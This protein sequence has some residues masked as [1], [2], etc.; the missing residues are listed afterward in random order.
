MKNYTKS[1]PVAFETGEDGTFSGYASK[2]GGVDFYG[3]TIF[4]G[5]YTKVIESG[6]LPKL[7]FNHDTRSVPIGV[8]TSIK[9][10]DVGLFVEGKLTLSIQQARDVY[11]GMKA[12]SIDGLSIGF[13]LSED[14]FELNKNGGM[15]IH[16]FSELREISVVTFPA[17][18]SA[19]ISSVKAAEEIKTIRDVEEFLRDAGISKSESMTLISKVKELAI[20]EVR[21]DSEQKEKAATARS[22]EHI[23]SKL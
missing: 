3:D 23:L 12:G 15:D 8:Y 16:S 13:A 19:R 2:F 7:F 1:Q 14:D 22:I 4:P 6:A 18:K 9:Q 10:D 21:R 5:A 17:D 11:E 20:A